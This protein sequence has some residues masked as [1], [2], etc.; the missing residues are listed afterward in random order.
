MYNPRRLPHRDIWKSRWL[1]LTVRRAISP[2]SHEK[3]RRLWTVFFSISIDM[4]LEKAIIG[5]WVDW[6]PFVGFY[7]P[8]QHSST[9]TIQQHPCKCLFVTWMFLSPHLV[10]SV[11]HALHPW[12]AN[13]MLKPHPSPSQHNLSPVSHDEPSGF[14]EALSGWFNISNRVSSIKGT[15]SQKMFWI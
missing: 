8:R 6:L 15:I 14:D 9:N 2:R 3:N 11:S 4:C 12:E 1:P 7:T 10:R 13:Q 5:G